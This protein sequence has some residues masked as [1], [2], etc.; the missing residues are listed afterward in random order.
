MLECHWDQLTPIE[1]VVN[2]GFV[3]RIEARDPTTAHQ[4]HTG[5]PGLAALYPIYESEPFQRAMPSIFRSQRHGRAGGHDG[6]SGG[7]RR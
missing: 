2:L 7:L 1:V 4:S 5:L 6:I 3:G